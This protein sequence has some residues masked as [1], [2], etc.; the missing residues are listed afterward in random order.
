MSMNVPLTY[1]M[2]RE[3][4]ASHGRSWRFTKATSPTWECGIDGLSDML[5]VETQAIS[6]KTDGGPPGRR[7]RTVTGATS[8]IAQQTDT[9]GQTKHLIVSRHVDKGWSYRLVVTD[10]M[11][12]RLG[13]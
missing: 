7:L 4:G 1:E 8:K 3:E 10:D 2:V 11:R 5:A 13:V 9:T 12:R 6:A